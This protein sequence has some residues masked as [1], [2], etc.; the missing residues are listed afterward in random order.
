LH[1]TVVIP[2]YNE[3]DCIGPLLRE[4]VSTARGL[5]VREIIVVDD[6]SSDATAARAIEAGSGSSVTAS[7]RARVGRCSPASGPPRT[8]SS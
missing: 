3:E 5:P 8:T 4:V 7:A 1:A 2:A 6:G